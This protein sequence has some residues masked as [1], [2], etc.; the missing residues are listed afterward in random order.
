M[1]NIKISLIFLLSSIFSLNLSAVPEGAFTTLMV[2]AKDIDKYV[3]FL[4]ENVDFDNF[5]SEQAGYCKTRTGE[6]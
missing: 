1:K 5:G 3:D 4:K 6:S 2:Q